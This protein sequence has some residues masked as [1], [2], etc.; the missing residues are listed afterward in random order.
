[1]VFKS[2]I[3]ATCAC[4]AV[5]SFNVSA[6]VVSADW[7]TTVGDNLIT[8][9]TVSKLDWLDLTETNGL[10]YNYVSGQF[11]VGGQFDGWRYATNSEVVALWNN[12]GIDLSAGSSYQVPGHDPAVVEAVGFLG[13]LAEY[14]S[15]TTLDGVAG[16][17]V[18][19]VASNMLD[20]IGAATIISGNPLSDYTVYNPVGSFTVPTTYA[21]LHT[22]SYL[23]K[24][25]VVPVPPAA[26]LFGSGLLGLIGIARCKSHV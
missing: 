20:T 8:H 22:G 11:G 17:T 26:W 1:M 21:F 12:F 9:D 13:N 10:S 18:D 16:M 25:S 23:V 7:L 5:V 3:G 14:F 19:G 24:S 4:L 15:V 2:I 6:A